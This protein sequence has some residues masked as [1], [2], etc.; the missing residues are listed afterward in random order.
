MKKEVS[1]KKEVPVK[2]KATFNSRI[3]YQNLTNQPE[4][5]D[6]YNY[7]TTVALNSDPEDLDSQIRSMITKSD[8]TAG[9]S[10][11]KMAT[12][13]VCGKQ[14]P[15]NSMP[16]H[17]EALHITGASHTCDSC[18]KI[19]RSRRILSRHKCSDNVEW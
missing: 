1:D 5:T 12:C 18:G 9:N 13:N 15:Y 11:G 7:N 2:Q 3:E 17:V 6:N 16:R 4:Q 10:Q 19:F 14:G 8:T